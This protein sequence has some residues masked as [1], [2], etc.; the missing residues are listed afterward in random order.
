MTKSNKVGIVGYW[1]ASNYGG[2][3]SYYSLYQKINDLGYEP[4]LID[5]PYFATDQEGRDVFSRNFF[6]KEKASMAPSYNSEELA[7]L[8][9][10]AD[11][12]VLG[13]DQVLTSFG[14]KV[15]GKLFLMEFAEP[16]KK[17]I[18][19]SASCGGDALNAEADLLE[20]ARSQ[21]QQFSAVSVREHAAVDILQSKFGVSAER[22]LDPIFFMSAHKLRELASKAPQISEKPYML[23]YVLDPTPDKKQCIETIAQQLALPKKIALDGRKFTYEGNFA[24]MDMP[25]DTLPEL[26]EYQWLNAYCNADYIFTDSYH[27]A[28]LATILNKPFIIYAN[29]D[30]G[31]PRFVTLTNMF[32]TQSRMIENSSELTAE[33][34]NNEIDFIKINKIIESEVN[35]ATSWLGQSLSQEKKY[36][37]NI[38][39]S[40]I[41]N[42]DIPKSC[43][44]CSACVNTCPVD[45]LSLRP[46]EF[47][48]YRST[49]DFDK[50]INCGLCTKVCP[51]IALP[52]NNNS[53]QPSLFEYISADRDV[54]Q[55]SSSGGIFTALAE[56]AFEKKGV[57]VGAAWTDDFSVE[58]IIIYSKKELSKLQKSKYLQSYM[59]TTFRKVKDL[60]DKNIFVLYTGCPCQVAG[61]RA[62]LKKDYANLI[63][64]DLLCSHTPSAKFF[65]KYLEDAFGQKPDYY[66]FRAKR[67]G[68]GANCVGVGVGGKDYI[69]SGAKDDDFQRVFHNHT[70][71]P[72]HCEH[73]KY[74]TIPRFGDLTIGD[75][76]GISNHDKTVD[77]RN[78][79]SAVLCNNEKGK[80]LF[81]DIPRKKAS[82]KKEVPLA[83]LGGN[84][85]ALGG[86]HNY[87]SPQR[88][89]FYK[90][91]TT[92]PFS[93]AVDYALK[94]NHGIYPT[95]G[96]LAYRPAD[97]HFKFDPA[98]WEEHYIDR[99][100]V[101]TTKIPYPQTGLFATI[102]LSAS[103]NKG[104]KY[105]LKARIKVMTSAKELNFH[106]KDSG[107]NIFQ[108]IYSLKLPNANGTEW[109]EF[110]HD[111]VADAKFYDEFMFGASQIRGE[112]R[113][114]MIDYIN[115]V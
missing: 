53:K 52:Q 70:M 23:A 100:V 17:R 84:G 2:V 85:Y 93:K 69:F 66:D 3:A 22:L 96:A 113:W 67:E 73:C 58:H 87:C 4:F 33:K 83:W 89:L 7:K 28:V 13:S 60:L 19:V 51:A 72:P 14:I 57:V 86:S 99:H 15:F 41:F 114:L 78:G 9:D 91:I 11:T 102:P 12:F 105:T 63:A 108:V 82:V 38:S 94:P 106:I 95:P 71:C 88:D 44:G 111:F 64:V 107:S 35:Y 55:K 92:M 75:F 62:Y 50:C 30:R 110:S 98:I 39:Q 24:K 48:Y 26:D 65:S 20:F 1:F 37:K 56:L 112:S 47:G 59:G 68:W 115:I 104:Q 34:I 79:I 40:V 76:W 101:L 5:T 109:I 31:Y 46:D 43:M 61:L 54:L 42:L 32:G 6:A 10:L 45:A 27:G 77:T 49:I 18:A 16:N 21:L 29:H 103:L 81:E 97:T 8:N 36:V 80:M 25:N 90:A 74:Q